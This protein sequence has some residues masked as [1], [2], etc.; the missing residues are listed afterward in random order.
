M[1]I[2]HMALNVADP[3]EMARWYVAH[4]GFQVRRRVMEPPWAHF[5]ADET[6]QVILEIYGRTD[7]AV[8]DYANTHSGTLHLALL[9]Q[10]VAVDAERLVR[11]G[12]TREGDVQALPGGS[13][14]IFLRD[15]WGLC[16]QLIRRAEPLLPE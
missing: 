9:S 14:M 4:L 12:C 1:R 3:L 5:I 13:E 11:A 16:L 2:E 15:P 7:L 6:G 10:D 8:P